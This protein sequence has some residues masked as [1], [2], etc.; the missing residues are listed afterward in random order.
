MQNNRAPT[1]S[2]NRIYNAFPLHLSVQMTLYRPLGMIFNYIFCFFRYTHLESTKIHNL[3]KWSTCWIRVASSTWNVLR[4]WNTNKERPQKQ[5][6]K[7]I[8]K[9]AN[10]L[11]E[12][13]RQRKGVRMLMLKVA[14]PNGLNSR[15]TK[16]EQSN[17]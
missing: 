5:V 11:R 8:W 12:S 7:V 13:Q 4:L 16:L 10:N 14:S 1:L 6:Q 17:N 2:L 15:R 3:K 9:F